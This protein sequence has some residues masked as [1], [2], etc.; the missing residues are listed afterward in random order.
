M[1]ALRNFLLQE[2]GCQEGILVILGCFL[3]SLGFH[4]YYKWKRPEE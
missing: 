4:F 2:G 3:I 1:N